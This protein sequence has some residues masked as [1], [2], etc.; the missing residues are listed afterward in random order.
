V[1]GSNSW[2]R[3]ADPGKRWEF[4][5]LVSFQGRVAAAI[6]GLKS[7][8]QPDLGPKRLSFVRSRNNSVGF[9]QT[10]TRY[11]VRSIGQFGEWSSAFAFV[12]GCS[13][14]IDDGFHGRFLWV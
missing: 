5:S 3:A 6:W 13:D 10:A 14:L 11:N 12:P 8:E 2:K 9:I 1:V 4:E 7:I